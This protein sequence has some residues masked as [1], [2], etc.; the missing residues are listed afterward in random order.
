MSSWHWLLWLLQGMLLAEAARR[1]DCLWDCCWRIRVVLSHWLLWLLLVL[2]GMLIAWAGR[3]WSKAAVLAVCCLRNTKDRMHLL[4]DRRGKFTPCIVWGPLRLRDS[5]GRRHRPRG[6][7]RLLINPDHSV[8]L[9]VK[10]SLLQ[11]VQ[12]LVQCASTHEVPIRV[13]FSADVAIIVR[14]A[15]DGIPSASR[16]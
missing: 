6:S 15:C 4:I 8:V 16:Q 9:Y 14:A 7:R 1:Y 12:M 3:L 13:S 2:Q 10:A 11:R 5:L